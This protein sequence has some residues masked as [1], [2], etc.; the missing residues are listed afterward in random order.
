MFRAAILVEGNSD[1]AAVLA[2]AGAQGTD[3]AAQGV[4]VV[5]MGGITNTARYICEL[6]PKGQRLRLAGLYDAG[7]ERFVRSGLIRGGFAPDS[8]SPG[9]AALGFHRCDRDLEEEL[10]RAVG[11]DR[12][13][14]V[15][16]PQGDLVPFRTLQQQPA[17][18]G[19]PVTGHLH[20]FLG[21]GSGRKIRYGRLLVDALALSEMPTPL[22]AVLADAVGNRAPRSM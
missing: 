4:I 15:L 14:A 21:A 6:G 18:R 3:L 16:E 2:L 8:G 1:R 7:E 22:T 17:H 5:A 9:L 11:V 10:I 19:G 20:R 12:M 13:L